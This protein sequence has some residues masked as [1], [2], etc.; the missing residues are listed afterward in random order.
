METVDTSTVFST[1]GETSM[2]LSDGWKERLKTSK[3]AYCEFYSNEDP[4][5]KSRG[6]LQTFVWV[7]GNFVLRDI[8]HKVTLRAFTVTNVFY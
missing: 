6:I 7:G 5:P 4:A 1:L 8:V 3:D 2:W